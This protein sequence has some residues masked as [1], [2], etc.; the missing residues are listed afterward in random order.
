MAE[1]DGVR[2]LLSKQHGERVDGGGRRMGQ[3]GEGLRAGL[4]GEYDMGERGKSD[5]CLIII[6]EFQSQELHHPTPTSIP[7][8]KP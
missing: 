5:A 3:R 7:I 8:Y 4:R 2:W 1:I 6:A